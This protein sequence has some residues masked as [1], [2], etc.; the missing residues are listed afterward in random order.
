MSDINWAEFDKFPED[1]CYCK[2]GKIYRS[3]VKIV[4]GNGLILVSRNPCPNCQETK[5][6][7]RKVSSD[8]EKWII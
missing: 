3:H 8:P 5:G 6:H 1:A 4:K 7:L 2:C